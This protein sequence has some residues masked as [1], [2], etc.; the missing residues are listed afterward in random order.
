MDNLFGEIDC[1][2]KSDGIVMGI[3]RCAM[4]KA[5][6]KVQSEAG[7]IEFLHERSKFY[8]LAVILVESG[9]SIVQQ[10]TNI[11]ESNREK[12]ISDL[13]EMRHWLL[14]RINIMKLLINE[15]DRELTERTENE[16]KL[17]QVLES[18]EK[19]VIFLRDKLENRRTMSEGSLDLGLLLKNNEAKESDSKSDSELLNEERF[20]EDDFYGSYNHI[21]KIKPMIDSLRPEQNKEKDNGEMVRVEKQWRCTIEKDILFVLIRGFINDIKQRFEIELRNFLGDQI[22]VGFSNENLSEFISEMT[23]LCQEL[24]AFYS[25]YNEDNKTT[26]SNQDLLG[27]LK[28]IKRTCSEPLPKFDQ[29]DQEVG[30]SNYV[31]KLIKNHQSVI[32]KQLEDR[33]VMKKEV[34]EGEK[35]T[36]HKKDKEL[37]FLNRM[38]KHVITRL[39]DISSMNVKSVDKEYV[40]WEEKFTKENLSRSVM[41][42]KLVTSDCAC[43]IIKDE[44]GSLK[45]EVD[46]LNLQILILEEIH[47]TLYEGLFKDQSVACFK[48]IQNTKSTSTLLLR[49][50][51]VEDGNSET[52]VK[53]ILDGSIIPETIGSLLKEDVYE[54]FFVEMFKAW[55]EESDDFDMEVHIREELYNCIMAEAVK[56]EISEYL[57]SAKNK[58]VEFDGTEES[59]IQKLD[60]LLKSLESEEDLMVKTSFEIE[61]H[62]VCHEQEILE[63][64]GVEE[65]ETIEWLLN[66]DESTFSSMNEKLEI[67][68]KQLSTS[69]ELLFDLE[70]SLGFSADALSKSSD[71]CLLYTNTS[72]VVEMEKSSQESI[73]QVEDSKV[74]LL[75]LSDFHQVIQ[76]F[77][78]NVVKNLVMKSSRIEE[79]KHQFHNLIVEPV[80]L[81]KKRKLLYKKAFLARCQNLKLAET[82]VFDILKLIKD[83]LAHGVAC[84]SSS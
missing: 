60:S 21:P 48:S 14:G 38:I 6:E 11:L 32:R 83:E 58:K 49:Q 71:D 17:R 26:S 72:L 34:I 24:E 15:K 22:P 63:C 84:A 62:N 82:E 37:D 46:N 8:E 69:K 54:V 66:D 1:R 67:A 35:S 2:S 28:N 9:L 52:F 79:L 50:F 19:E 51:V 61:E 10:E 16:L 45:E 25:R 44:V 39:D 18:K 5:H 23:T 31:A 56:D 65:H 27:H 73:A 40:K 55:K 68:M 76:E 7:S 59:P 81:I 53:D 74:A 13:T 64:E 20:Q 70:Q 29:E 78:V 36:L 80:S 43:E 42:D 75:N 3:L 12:V 4:D 47:L 41:G 57:N 77:E 30:G 33:N